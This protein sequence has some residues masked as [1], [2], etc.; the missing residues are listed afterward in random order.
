MV[1]PTGYTALDL[2]GYTDKG[3]YNSASTY[4]RNDLVH[5]NSSIWRCLVD[6]T[7][8]VTPSEGA[9]WTIFIQEPGTMTG[10]T[11]IAAGSSGLAPAPAAG[12]N[13]K[14]LRGDGTWNNPPLPADMTGATSSDPGSHGLVPAPRV[15]D[16]DSFLKGD[17]SWDNPTAAPMIGATALT[18]GAGGSAP[19][20]LAGD[21]DKVLS[22]AG[23]YI[24]S[25]VNDRTLVV[26]LSSISS[27]PQTANNASIESDMVVV[28]SVLSN[29]SAQTGEWTVSTSSGSLTLSG[30]ISGT[31]NVT[32]Y[33][34][35]SR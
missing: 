25:V 7:T 24:E 22:G 11:A 1:N 5:Y 34:M 9:T 23:T 18:D 10:A 2:I 6:D 3:T 33:L 21:Q 14:F 4:V 15:A 19:K 31:T 29:P 20:P 32:L 16:R 35:R 26:T 13:E 27:L 30:N 8:A 28:N 12:D 17:G